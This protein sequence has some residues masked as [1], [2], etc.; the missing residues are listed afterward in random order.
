MPYAFL[1]SLWNEMTVYS[2]SLF[3]FTTLNKS[4][5]ISSVPKEISSGVHAFQGRTDKQHDKIIASPDC[6]LINEKL[7]FKQG[8]VPFSHNSML[9]GGRCNS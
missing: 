7:H 9:T 3:S 5:I 8:M 2:Y 1:P 4:S 6:G